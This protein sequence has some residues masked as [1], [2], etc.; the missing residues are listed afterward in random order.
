MGSVA[1]RLMLITRKK[2]MIAVWK[3]VMPTTFFMR[4]RC[5][6]IVYSPSMRSAMAT[7]YG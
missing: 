5:A 6:I 1:P 7:Q 2:R 4:L 3:M